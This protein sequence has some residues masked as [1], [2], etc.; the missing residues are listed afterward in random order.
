VFLILTRDAPEALELP[1]RRLSFGI[2]QT[3]QALADQRELAARGRRTLRLHLGADPLRGL[4]RLTRT[5]VSA[6]G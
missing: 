4:D 1:G 6:L 3:A 2:V 5:A